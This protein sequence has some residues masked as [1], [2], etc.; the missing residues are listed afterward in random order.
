MAKAQW[1]SPL[2][3][4]RASPPVT[5]ANSLWSGYTASRISYNSILNLVSSVANIANIFVHHNKFAYSSYHSWYYT[6]P[7]LSISV[8]D[9]GRQHSN[10]NLTLAFLFVPT[11]RLIDRLHERFKAVRYTLLHTNSLPRIPLFLPIKCN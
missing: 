2:I 10:S 5:P 7:G 4:K 9:S 8:Q 1:N 11:W 3:N 6:R